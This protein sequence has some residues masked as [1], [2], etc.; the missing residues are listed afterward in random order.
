MDDAHNILTLLSNMQ[1][2]VY[3]KV[4]CLSLLIFDTVITEDQEYQ[5]I[6]RR[7]WSL[8]KALYLFIRYGTFLDTSIAVYERL[9]RNIT[10]CDRIMTFN[11]GFCVVG[12]ALSEI[13]LILRTYAIYGSSRRILAFLLSLW[14]ALVCINTWAVTRWTSTSDDSSVQ[15][16]PSEFR[17]F[18]NCFFGGSSK[19]LGLVCYL[20]LMGGETVVVA[21]TVGKAWSQ[22]RLIPRFL[23]KE[24]VYKTNS[25]KAFA[26]LNSF[27]RDGILFYLCL[28]PLTI[29]NVVAIL[30]LPEGLLQVTDT[31]LR[32]FHTI[33]VCRLV[34]HVRRIADSEPGQESLVDD[35]VNSLR[36]HRTADLEA[37]TSC[38]HQCSLLKP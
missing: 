4:A 32:V 18:T 16:I 13:I 38:G 14:L 5:Y 31:P 34:L 8:V 33:L 22:H 7:K 23:F 27:Y 3:V 36:F 12:I 1:T 25:L 20:T 21:L 2:I 29:S 19:T 17:P 11:S 10:D 35:P 30:Y 9:G 24:S 6:W 26:L 15:D 28:L 37:E